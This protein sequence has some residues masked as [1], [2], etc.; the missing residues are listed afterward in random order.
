[1]KNEK[2]INACEVY[3]KK[4]KTLR[5][6]ESCKDFFSKDETI[7]H[8]LWMLYQIPQ[9]IETEDP[10]EKA[11]RWLGFV[12]GVLWAKEIYTIEE[13]KEHNRP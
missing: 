8:V 1:M 7:S 10:E 4:L 3:D 2:I 6:D 13:M 11:N 5:S 9:F 12:Q